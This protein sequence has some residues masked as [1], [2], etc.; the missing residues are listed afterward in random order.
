MLLAGVGVSW[1]DD[2]SDKQAFHDF[3][4]QAK[5]GAGTDKVAAFYKTS[6]AYWRQ[7]WLDYTNHP[8]NYADV[9]ALYRAN[10]ALYARP[11]VVPEPERYRKDIELFKEFD[12]KNAAPKDPALFG[13]F[14]A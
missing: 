10:Q 11:F 14:A 13:Y 6:G 5:S 7:H 1:A 4:V 3:L 12:S 9:M 8:E 2:A